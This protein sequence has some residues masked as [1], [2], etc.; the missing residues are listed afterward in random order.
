[1]VNF[2]DLV[3]TTESAWAGIAVSTA[4][5]PITASASAAPRSRVIRL[6]AR[7]AAG[8]RGDDMAHPFMG[9]WP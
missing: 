9:K 5:M 4:D 7:K 3:E 8:V 2:A 1:M 6:V